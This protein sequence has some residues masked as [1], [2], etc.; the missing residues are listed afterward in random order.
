MPKTEQS[1]VIAQ[2]SIPNPQ[3]R[4]SIL[5]AMD[6]NRVIGHRGGLPW[7]ISEDLKRFKALTMGHPIIMGRKTFES[8]G[9]VL[10]GRMNVIVTRQHNFSAPAEA[11]IAQSMEDALAI[12][13]AASEVFVV[14]GRDLYAVALPIV[15]R[16]Y[17]T[18]VGGEFEGDTFFPE[19]ELAGWREVSREHRAVSG[20]GYNGYDFVVY[21]RINSRAEFPAAES[22]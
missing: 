9:R 4:L 12:T 11:R 1:P 14:G 2:S 3:C 5:V 18:E 8:I 15:H 16:I 19:F 13:G 7:H 20:E 6:R 10:P 22:R 21:D 17:L